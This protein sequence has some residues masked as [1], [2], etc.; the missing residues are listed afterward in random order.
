MKNKSSKKYYIYKFLFSSLLLLFLAIMIFP[1]IA[2]E[3]KKEI[4]LDG[5]IFD[6]TVSLESDYQ[7]HKGLIWIMN[8]KKIALNGKLGIDYS[9]DYYGYDPITKSERKILG[10]KNSY[11]FIYITD[12]YGVY[13]NEYEGIAGGKE[14]ITGGF[15]K[16]EI[17]EL[18]T[19]LR[20]GVTLIGEFNTLASPTKYENRLQLEDIFGIKW[21][22][23][24]GRYYE[25]L[26]YG[27]EIGDWTVKR[28]EEESGKKW[29]F[30]GPG[31]VLISE[32]DYVAVLQDK[33]DFYDDG[34]KFRFLD[35]EKT[36]PYYYWFEILEETDNSK[37]EAEYS[38]NLTDSGKKTFSKLGL[39]NKFPAI[40]FGE[41]LNY[42]SY[43][44][45]GDY[46]DSDSAGGIYKYQGITKFKTLFSLESRGDKESFFWKVYYPYISDVLDNSKINISV[47]KKN[48]VEFRTYENFFQK[49]S[50][51]GEWE[52]YVVKGVNMGF[53]LPGKWFREFPDRE[54]LYY[55]WFKKISE[56][57]ANTIRV[58]TLMDPSFYRALNI[59]NHENKNEPLYLMQEIWPEEEVP[60]GNF[61]DEEYQ[62][63]YEKEIRYA[64]DAIHG[65]AEIEERFGRAYGKYYEDVSDYLVGYLI[66]RELEPEQVM[67]TDE[68]NKN[69][70]FDGNYF[71]N[72]ENASPTEG[73]LA[74]NLDYA[75]SYEMNKYNDSHMVSIVNWPT[76]DKIEHD[77]EWNE[78]GDKNLQFNDK[79]VIDINN[80]EVK[81]TFEKGLFGS[82]HIYPNYPDFMNNESYYRKFRDNQGRL[83][84][85]GYLNEFIE[86]HKKYPA[87]VAEFGLANGMKTA[88]IN[89]DSLNHGGISEINQGKGIVRMM[90]SILD[91][92]YAGALIFEWLDEWAKKT[93]T[94]EPFMIP[95]EEHIYWHNEI[96]P[97]QNYG[98]VSFDVEPDIEREKIF[99]SDDS[100]INQ[101]IYGFSVNYDPG[102]LHISMKTNDDFD[103]FKDKIFIGIDTVDENR[104]DFFFEENR[105]NKCGSGNEFL[106]ELN[107]NGCN[108]KALP[109]YNIGNGKYRTDSFYAGK[110][111]EILF[112]VNRKVITKDGEVIEEKYENYSKMKYGEF[113]DR[114]NNWY[115]KDNIINIRIP[116]TIL[117]F[118]DPRNMVVLNEYEDNKELLR[119]NL[120]TTRSDGIAFNIL[121]KKEGGDLFNYTTKN[122]RYFWNPWETI[123]YKERTKESYPI[124]RDYFKTIN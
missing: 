55:N 101:A 112:L 9:K 124:I 4:I 114:Q 49:K 5:I 45:A 82:Y 61:F 39:K 1:R 91:E 118:T 34:I 120:S 31:I 110:Y 29:R 94:T 73:W 74:L 84:Y 30:S 122:N 10:S 12:T 103:F 71:Y 36:Y 102:F 70:K 83:M 60:E 2:W 62:K 64:I 50:A 14:K 27:M 22:G 75:V 117:N 77:S 93:W 52:K 66:G 35:S 92:G 17:A 107:S 65:N 26:S 72:S 116:W 48:D 69:Y 7:E 113:S 33:I 86:S 81:D 76:L 95:Y 58:Y 11:D 108:I 111:E 47:G 99:I 88:H 54:N 38:I 85:R 98:I 3:L 37:V 119:D 96:D 79:A 97:E 16:D 78:K 23:W 104:G 32:K 109:S 80:I 51:N 25:D 115:V 67:E 21:S 100:D 43:Y 68:I 90:K 24:I 53:A 57:N 105:Y 63:E 89:P 56:M 59:F 13:K 8:Y 19:V 42:Q 20:N 15:D 6:K 87:L 40:V 121:Y 46:S 123:N 18:K 44:F 41:N 106:I 28:Y